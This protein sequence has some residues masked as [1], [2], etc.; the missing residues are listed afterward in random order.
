M[1]RNGHRNGLHMSANILYTM[2]YIHKSYTYIYSSAT[3]ILHAR[4]YTDTVKCETYTHTHTHRI[5][6]HIKFIHYLNSAPKKRNTHWFFFVESINTILYVSV[7]TADHCLMHGTVVGAA[8]IC[9]LFIFFCL[10]DAFADGCLW[11]SQLI[12]CLSCACIK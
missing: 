6:F 12:E 11:A 5:H 10:T 3:A 7:A 8:L 9:F 1:E 4:L 2:L